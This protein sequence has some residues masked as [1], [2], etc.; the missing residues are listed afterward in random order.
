MKTRLRPWRVLAACTVLLAGC[1]PVHPPFGV[2]GASGPIADAQRHHLIF[3][4]GWMMVVVLP[5]FIGL[6][7]VVRRYRHG[8]TADDFRP[9]WTFSWPLELLV[10]GVPAIVAGVLGW[11]LWQETVRLDPY[12]PL[13]TRS[14]SIEVDVV[15]LDWKWLFIY[16]RLGIASADR[17]V[18]PA[19]APVRFR[20]TSGTVLQSFMIPRLGGQIYAMPGMVS[21]LSLSADRPGTFTGLNTQYNGSGF[22]EQ[23]FEVD[24]LPRADFDQWVAKTRREAPPLDRKVMARLGRRDVLAS[25]E[26]F[27]R[28]KGDPFAQ[29][30][31]TAKHE[32]HA[33]ATAP[34]GQ[35]R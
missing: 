13:A 26:A 31:K 19:G 10:W 32:G 22:S 5:V 29:V 17:L 7:L 14:A 1:G 4:T 2:F 27:G 35:S 8:Q 16:P 6:P 12:K 33:V 15:G 18:I 11:Q 20:I 30:V 34:K 9:G 25:P 23:R 21:A 3:V 24:A 28:L